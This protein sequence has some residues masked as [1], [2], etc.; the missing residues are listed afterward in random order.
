MGVYLLNEFQS[1][2]EKY[3]A[4]IKRLE[5]EIEMLEKQLMTDDLTGALNRVGAVQY[6]ADYINNSKSDVC[7]CAMIIDINNLKKINDSYGHPAG[8][9]ALC[10]IANILKDFVAGNGFV[11]R[12]GGDEFSVFLCDVK[13]KEQMINM[14]K[15]LNNFIET[16]QKN[17]SSQHTISVSI[18][19]MLV[20]KGDSQTEIY[21]N[22]DRLMYKSKRNKSAFE[23]E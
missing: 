8:D 4:K 18:G 22:T 9:K 19:A 11:A 14:L 3:E 20:H 21:K 10:I 2:I 16:K 23:Y 12:F 7:G 5:S 1:K 13:Q 15:E 6:L 17:S